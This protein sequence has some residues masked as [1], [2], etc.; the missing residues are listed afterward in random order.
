MKVVLKDKKSLISKT[1][2]VRFE[3]PIL[4]KRKREEEDSEIFDD[5]EFY[6]VLLRDLIEDVGSSLG[7][8]ESLRNAI[9]KNIKKDKR[10]FKRMKDKLIKYVPHPKLVGFMAPEEQIIPES[11]DVLFASIFGGKK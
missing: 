9:S 2:K 10:P 6:Q 4:G 8:G 3:E 1:Q 11:T 5:R 7:S